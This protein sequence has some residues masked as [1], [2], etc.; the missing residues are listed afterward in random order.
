[1]RVSSD[2]LAAWRH[3]HLKGRYTFR[4]A[5]QVIDLDEIVA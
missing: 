1:M 4:A 3:I 2:S 5:G